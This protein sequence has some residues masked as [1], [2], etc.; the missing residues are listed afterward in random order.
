MKLGFSPCP[1]DT[2]IFYALANHLID[3]RGYDIEFV[4]DEVESLNRRAMVGELPVSK[5][6]CAAFI[7]L[8]DRYRFLKSGGAFGRGC[9]P[10]VVGRKKVDASFLQGRTIAIPGEATT[11]HLLIRLY[12]DAAGVAPKAFVPMVFH[13][14]MPAVAAGRVDAGVIIHEGRFTFGSWHLHAWID[15]GGWWEKTTGL[16]LPLGGIVAEKALGEKTLQDLEGLIRAS[17]GYASAHP[18]EAMPFIRRHAQEMADDVIRQHI[19]LYVN[20]FS[21]DIGDEG[22]AALD[23]LL[24][25]ASAAGF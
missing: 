22:T 19:A 15:L 21:M 18:G 23:E 16:P 8:R 14:V 7:R 9:G 5:V 3:S 1:N 17:V 13:E 11:A 6:S 4:I 24:R 10:L 20:E 2:Y 25:R 12:C